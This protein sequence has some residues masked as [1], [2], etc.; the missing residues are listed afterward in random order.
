MR[1]ILTLTKCCLYDIK[2]GVHRIIMA[3]RRKAKQNF[4]CKA[5]VGC[6]SWRFAYFFKNKHI[7]TIKANNKLSITKTLTHEQTVISYEE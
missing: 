2:L 4:L 6:D 5:I 1:I 3:V 7:I